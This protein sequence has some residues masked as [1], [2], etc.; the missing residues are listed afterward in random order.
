MKSQ[1]DARAIQRYLVK[2]VDEGIYTTERGYKM[3][4]KVRF[5]IVQVNQEKANGERRFC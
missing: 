5:G 4:E 1:Q 3:P 2:R